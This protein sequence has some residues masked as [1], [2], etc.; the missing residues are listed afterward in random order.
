MISKYHKFD[1]PNSGAKQKSFCVASLLRHISS[2]EVVVRFLPHT[3]PL[4]H[5]VL[6]LPRQRLPRHVAHSNGEQGQAVVAR[7]VPLRVS[8]TDRLVL[9]VDLQCF[10]LVQIPQHLSTCVTK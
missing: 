1:G 2:T 3:V 7:H 9:A 6:L 8:M 5:C 10:W 4:V